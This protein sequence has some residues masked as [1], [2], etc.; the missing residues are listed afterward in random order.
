MRDGQV[1]RTPPFITYPDCALAA[2]MTDGRDGGPARVR[3]SE[4]FFFFFSCSVNI[5]LIQNMAGIVKLSEAPFIGRLKK[6]K[7]LR[8]S[9]LNVRVGF[10]SM[11]YKHS[12]NI[13]AGPRLL[14]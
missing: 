6:E 8:P 4:P 13:L 12:G 7:A 9:C 5:A 11:T 14:L 1:E 3:I 2:P 10:H